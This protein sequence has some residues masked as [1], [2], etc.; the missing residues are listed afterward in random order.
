MVRWR[1]N[2]N[3][4][5]SAAKAANAMAAA[6][7]LGVDSMISMYFVFVFPI[8]FGSNDSCQYTNDHHF[9]GY[10]DCDLRSFQTMICRQNVKVLFGLVFSQRP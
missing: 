9:I 6:V 3:I 1:D 2:Q 10:C 8:L 4:I 5:G 7:F